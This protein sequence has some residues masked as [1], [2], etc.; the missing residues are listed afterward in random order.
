[1]IAAA[2]ASPCPDHPQADP[3]LDAPARVQH[4]ELGQDG[5]PDAPGDGVQADQR[6]VADRVEEGVED[7]HP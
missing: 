7:S 6:G 3:V 4:L 5:R 1:L 2:M